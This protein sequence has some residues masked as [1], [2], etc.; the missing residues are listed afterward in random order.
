[1]TDLI[2]R[3]CRDHL[4]R[5]LEAY[6]RRRAELLDPAAVA[7]ATAESLAPVAEEA[8]LPRKERYDDWLKRT[9]ATLA[10]TERNHQ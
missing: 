6:D 2:D 4:A 3:D 8:P 7:S 9:T 5:S 10:E 1:V